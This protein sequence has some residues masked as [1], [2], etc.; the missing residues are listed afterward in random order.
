MRDD[1]WQCIL[2][3]RTNVNEMNIES[4]D[5]GGEV[6]YGFQFRL[7]LAPVIVCSPIASE[8]LHRHELHALRRIRYLLFVRPF[9]RVDA[10]AQISEFGVCKIELK[11][12]DRRFAGYLFGASGCGCCHDV[13]L[14]SS[15]GLRICKC[16]GDCPGAERDCET[17]HRTYF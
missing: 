3:F 9:R 10:S 13:L 15:S 6:W 1:H 14:L 4:I 17:Q 8:F 5:L 2:M 11:R 7:T 12:T 16:F